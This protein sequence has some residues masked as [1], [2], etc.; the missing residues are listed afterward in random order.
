[1]T[2]KEKQDFKNNP[3]KYKVRYIFREFIFD[4]KPLSK[5]SS[6]KIPEFQTLNTMHARW[7]KLVELAQNYCNLQDYQI[8]T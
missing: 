5:E 1:M 7:C 3:P 4:F 8:S 2:K 6:V